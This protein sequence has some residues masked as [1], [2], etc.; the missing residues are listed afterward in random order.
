MKLLKNNKDSLAKAQRE[1]YLN[2]N[3]LSN[4]KYAMELIETNI[5]SLAINWSRLSCN[6]NTNAI[7]L[8][9]NNI[10]KIDW[11]QISANENAI[12]L[13]K[14]NKDKINWRS[15]SHNINAIELIEENLDS[16]DWKYLSG[17]KNAIHL[18]EKI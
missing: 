9:E 15:L 1:T 17:N 11:L 10:D 13:L 16:I 12:Q 5:N 3:L 4:N 6:R 14:E 8:L 2:W 7:K 18:L